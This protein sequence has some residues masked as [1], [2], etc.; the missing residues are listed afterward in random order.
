M[1]ITPYHPETSNQLDLLQIDLAMLTSTHAQ[2]A[3]N[4][5]RLKA[6]REALHNA[7]RLVR[8]ARPLLIAILVV[9]FVHLWEQ[10]ASIKPSSVPDL[11]LHPWLYHGSSAMLTA[12]ID[13][14]A[15]YLVAT[16]ATAAYAGDRTRQY[17][18]WFFYVLTAILNLSFVLRFAPELPTGVAEV[19][20]TLY[21]LMA[22]LLGLLIPVS[23]AAVESARQRVEA[24]RLALLVETEALTEL[25][26]VA[27]VTATQDEHT[28]PTTQRLTPAESY[29]P[30]QFTTPGDPL[31]APVIDLSTI[32]QTAL[33]AMSPTSSVLAEQARRAAQRQRLAGSI[34]RCLTNLGVITPATDTASH[35]E[36]G[37]A[38]GASEPTEQTR[39]NTGAVLD[40]TCP[41]CQEPLN[42]SQYGNAKRLGYCHQCKSVSPT[43]TDAPAASHGTSWTHG[44]GGHPN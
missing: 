3:L 44:D 25:V 36:V 6:K 42:A 40:K 31:V 41:T 35:P 27:P 30:A 18:V 37:T 33:D 12:A 19:I 26:Q 17:S 13:A 23:I 29:Q 24:A 38:S 16:R 2:T 14:T 34:Q 22:I 9:S 7:N 39:D 4:R 15:L 10:I 21:L 1:T 8:W 32:E 20:P 5:G 43:N 11:A 28:A